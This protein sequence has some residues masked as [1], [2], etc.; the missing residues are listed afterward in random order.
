MKNLLQ[1][2][3]AVAIIILSV[4]TH[5]SKSFAQASASASV[6]ATIVIP[7]GVSKESDLEFDNVSITAN[8]N[9]SGASTRRHKTSEQQ[10]LSANSVGAS[11]TVS[12]YPDYTYDVTIDRSVTV[13]ANN[14]KLVVG[15]EAC[16]ASGSKKLSKDGTDTINVEGTLAMAGAG[17]IASNTE[18]SN[19]LLVTINNN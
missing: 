7:T 8:K 13:S 10:V 5:S 15:T 19:G 18:I 12:G 6:G 17:I 3:C 1:L 9:S 16:S 2:I 11:F 4:V 14:H